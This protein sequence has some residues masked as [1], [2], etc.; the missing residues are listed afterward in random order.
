MKLSLSGAKL[1]QDLLPDEFTKFI[2]YIRAL[3]LGDKPDYEYLGNLFRDRF[4]SEGFRDIF[5]WTINGDARKCSD[6][7]ITPVPRLRLA[8]IEDN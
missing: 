7:S 6:R 2:D 4:R 5:D 3:G 1:C 8:N